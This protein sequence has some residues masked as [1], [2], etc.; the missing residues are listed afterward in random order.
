M[1]KTYKI[2]VIP[3]DGIGKEVTPWAQKTLEKAAFQNA[4]LDARITHG[5]EQNRVVGLDALL[6]V[7]GQNRT[8]AQITLGTQV[9][10]LVLEVSY[11]F[12]GLFQSLLSPRSDFLA[13]DRHRMGRM[14]RPVA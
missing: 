9:E 8:I 7:L 1:A 3:G 6:F 11:A 2:A 10:V 13:V 12:S 4:G 14:G 5:T